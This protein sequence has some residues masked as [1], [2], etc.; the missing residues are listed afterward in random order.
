MFCTVDE[1][2]CFES[3]DYINFQSLPILDSSY[4]LGSSFSHI[5]QLEFPQFLICIVSDVNYAF[6]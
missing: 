3:H 5:S 4:F 1:T 6:D 2:F